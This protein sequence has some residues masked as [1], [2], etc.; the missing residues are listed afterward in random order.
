MSHR[1]IHSITEISGQKTNSFHFFNCRCAHRYCD[2]FQKC[3]EV[4]P[5]GPLATLRRLLLS[6]ESIES[7]KKWVL[8]NWFIV[9]LIISG[10]IS[11]LVRTSFFLFSNEFHIFALTVEYT[12]TESLFVSGVFI[13]TRTQILSTRLFGKEIN[14]KSKSVTIIHSATTETVRL[15]D[16]SNGVTILTLPDGL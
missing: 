11:L 14:R 10:I 9:S 6:E 7:F 1:D 15:P 2:V 8:S 3:R 12:K 4:D 13:G 16:D 5:A